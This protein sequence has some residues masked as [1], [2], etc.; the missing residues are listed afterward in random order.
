MAIDERSNERKKSNMLVNW[1]KMLFI[2]FA[3]WGSVPE[4]SNLARTSI[5]AKK[6]ERQHHKL[7]QQVMAI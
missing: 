2:L 6:F 5:H 3:F 7:L 1:N 4:V